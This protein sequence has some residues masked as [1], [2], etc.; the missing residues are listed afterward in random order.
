MNINIDD[1]KN[2]IINGYTITEL[3]KKYNCSKTTISRLKA[4]FSLN[5]GDIS[6]KIECSE[7]KKLIKRCNFKKHYLCNF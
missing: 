5:N 6:S 3:T 7:C 4:K 1:F 2:D